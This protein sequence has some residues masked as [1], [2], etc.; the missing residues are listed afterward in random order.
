MSITKAIDS[1]VIEYSNPYLLDVLIET[2]RK[3]SIKNVRCLPEMKGD[4][5]KNLRCN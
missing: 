3:I 5:K 4:E 2:S 1:S